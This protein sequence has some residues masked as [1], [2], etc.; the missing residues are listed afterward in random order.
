M[1]HVLSLPLPVGCI[2]AV[3]N[4]SLLH[5]NT[6]SWQTGIISPSEDEHAQMLSC[7][8]PKSSGLRTVWLKV[9]QCRSEFQVC[10]ELRK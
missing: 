1:H 6:L 7:I 9:P 10:E 8:Q 5:V 2:L 4:Y 3:A